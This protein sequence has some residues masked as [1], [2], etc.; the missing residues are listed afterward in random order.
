[1][2]AIEIIEIVLLFEDLGVMGTCSIA[3]R[4][5]LTPVSYSVH[6]HQNE[7]AN[8]IGTVAHLPVL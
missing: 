4:V 5:D 2:T 1:M 6:F 7:W 8:Q 3:V